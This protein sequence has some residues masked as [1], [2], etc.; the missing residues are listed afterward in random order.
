MH[1]HPLIWKF[2]LACHNAQE[3]MYRRMQLS[4][5]KVIEVTIDLKRH[6]AQGRVPRQMEQSLCHGELG[7]LEVGQAYRLL[8]TL[9]LFFTVF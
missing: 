7:Y 4:R 1:F 5:L 6:V 3:F 8:F 9:F 2:E